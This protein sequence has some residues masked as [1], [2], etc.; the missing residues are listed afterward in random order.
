MFLSGQTQIPLGKAH[1]HKAAGGCEMGEKPGDR[2]GRHK[3]TG[4]AEGLR[5]A[6]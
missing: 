2:K 3:G 6:V 4:T 5:V 1:S